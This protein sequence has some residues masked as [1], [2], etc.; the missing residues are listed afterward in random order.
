MLFSNLLIL[1][2]PHYTYVHVKQCF[3]S[4]EIREN[5]YFPTTYTSSQDDIGLKQKFFLKFHV[6]I[7]LFIRLL[8]QLKRPKRSHKK[9]H[10]MSRYC[11]TTRAVSWSS[12]SSTTTSGRCIRRPRPRSGRPRRWTCQRTWL[13]GRN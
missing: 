10:K 12:R 9:T 5:L 13:T 1:S 6:T 8:N 2:F 4:N 11:E 3:S 7:S